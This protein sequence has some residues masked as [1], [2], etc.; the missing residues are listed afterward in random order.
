MAN[1]DSILKTVEEQTKAL[2]QKLFQQYTQ[3][4]M[5]DVQDFLQKSKADLERW[6]QQLAE[7]KIDAGEFASLV[8]GKLD[9]A[10]MKA[11]KQA[12]LGQVQL[13]TFTN[14]VVDI[15]VQAAVAAIP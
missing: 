9:V 4:A 10:E 1:I 2:A 11:L 6:A 14:G 8:Q 15:I 13:D 12:G 7:K 3:Q 5:T